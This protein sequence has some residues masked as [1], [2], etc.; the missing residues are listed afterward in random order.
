MDAAYSIVGPAAHK[1]MKS[2]KINASSFTK[3]S[4]PNFVFVIAVIK[5]DCKMEQDAYFLV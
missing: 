3:N 2:L 4:T 1:C 5:R